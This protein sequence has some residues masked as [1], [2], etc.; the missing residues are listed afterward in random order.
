MTTTSTLHIAGLDGELVSLTAE[1]IEVLRS[2][3]VGSLLRPGDDGWSTRCR[4][5][6]A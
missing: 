1:Q 2:A 3:L 5:G 4:S 6:T